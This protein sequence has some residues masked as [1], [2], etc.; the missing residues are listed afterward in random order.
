MTEILDSNRFGRLSLSKLKE[1][2]ASKSVELPN[3]Y[4]EFLLKHNGGRPNP[5]ANRNPPTNI[6]WIYGLHNGKSW[7]SL[8]HNINILRHRIPEDTLPIA[9]DGLGNVFL[10]SLHKDTFGEVWFWDHEK[11]SNEGKASFFSNIIK[12]ASSFKEFLEGLFEW[13]PEDETFVE[14]ILRTNDIEGLREL[15]E[16]DYDVNS[17][18]E[19]NRSLIE[20]ATIKNRFEM[21]K[22]LAEIGVDQRTSLKLAEQNHRAFPNQGYSRIIDYL[23]NRNK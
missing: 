13:I 1:F 23:R 19:Y 14:T 7:A 5:S 20:K 22:V 9:N 12:A 6:Q 21:V 2:E 18:D 11:E 10:I 17:L 4:K 15:L 8:D 16:S 3:D